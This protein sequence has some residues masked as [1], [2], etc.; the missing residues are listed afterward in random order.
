M[1]AHT[2]PCRAARNTR[3]K[4]E[5]QELHASLTI[6]FDTEV[7][8]RNGTLG[9]CSC[10]ANSQT[11]EDSAS[12]MV[13][14]DCCRVSRLCCVSHSPKA[15]GADD[16]VRKRFFRVSPRFLTLLLPVA[17]SA[18]PLLLAWRAAGFFGVWTEEVAVDFGGDRRA[19]INSARVLREHVSA[20]TRKL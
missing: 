16:D 7:H 15:A 14:C 4:R 5:R 3:L 9:D 11:L 10:V 18:L 20:H 19:V 6:L 13:R 1:T 17:R 2:T 8:S 12:H